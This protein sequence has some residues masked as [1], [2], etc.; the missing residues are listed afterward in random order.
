MQVNAGAP[1]IVTSND[2]ID[3]WPDAMNEGDMFF[4]EE[5]FYASDFGPGLTS[6]WHDD[7]D[8]IGVDTG[9]ELPFV[10]E[11]SSALL[12]I[13]AGAGIGLTRSKRFW[14]L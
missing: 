6:V 5:I 4:Q 2:A 13:A 10:P 11:P 14:D 12:L 8:I 7:T 9:P 3:I 1:T